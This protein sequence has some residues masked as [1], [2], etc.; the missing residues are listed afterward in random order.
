M[1]AALRIHEGQQVVVFMD[2]VSLT[3]QLEDVTVD[4]VKLIRASAAVDGGR[5]P[6]SVDGTAFV[7]AHAVV[8]VQVIP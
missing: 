8:W 4:G 6:V 2:G 7:P 1:K 3:G 5:E